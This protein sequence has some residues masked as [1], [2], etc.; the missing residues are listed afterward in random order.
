[1]LR[2]MR[3]CLFPLVFLLAA[4]GSTASAPPDASAGDDGGLPEAAAD[5]T[6][7]ALADAPEDAAP[8]APDASAPK[9]ITCGQTVCRID[10]TC[11]AGKCAFACTG[12]T[13]PGDYATVQGAIDAL[14]SAG[15][16]ATICLD[17]KTYAEAQVLVRDPGDHGKALRIIGLSMDRSKIAGTTYVQ[18]GWSTVTFQG[19]HLAAG[20]T[21]NSMNIDFGYMGGKVS[22]L[23][24]R[25]SGQT[26]VQ[27]GDGSGKNGELFVDGCDIAVGKG[28]GVEAFANGTG[29]LKVTVQNSYA[30]ACGCAT[31]AAATGT[32]VIDLRFVDNT[33]VGCDMGLWL[34][35]NDSMTALYANDVFT[36]ATMYGV[37]R[38]GAGTQVTHGNNA[39]WGNASNYFGTAVDGPGYVKTD[40]LLDGTGPVPT[41]GQGSSCLGAGDATVAPPAD[42]YVVPRGAKADIGAVQTSP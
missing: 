2:R 40:C 37:R 23:A 35:V 42:F 21:S 32:G 14:A 22:I 6:S 26:G 9:P 12:S 24:S 20:A 8:D 15:K 13:V 16:D 30:H 36:G 31:S 28:Y 39:L 38:D 41:L 10:Q 17:E 33:V 27:A 29:T 11:N 7:D 25:L 4:C 19:V 34:D 18:S 1:M 5:A 3:R